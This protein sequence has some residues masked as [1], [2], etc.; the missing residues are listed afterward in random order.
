MLRGVLLLN[1]NELLELSKYTEFEKIH[2]ALKDLKEEN[3]ILVTDEDLESIL[4]EV[5]KPDE[6][7]ILESAISNVTDLLHLLRNP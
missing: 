3:R 2:I 4:D 6:N 7:K 1:S 5:G